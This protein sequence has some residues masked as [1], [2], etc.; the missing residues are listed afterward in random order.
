MFHIK[1]KEYIIFHSSKNSI[2]ILIMCY[3]N[4]SLI[5]YLVLGKNDRINLE[6]PKP[7]PRR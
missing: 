4:S 1:L 2:I 5:I 7:T 3:D 6:K